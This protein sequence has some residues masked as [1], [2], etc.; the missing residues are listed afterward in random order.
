[1]TSCCATWNVTSVLLYQLLASNDNI[2]VAIFDDMS[3]D[4][5]VAQATA[6]GEAWGLRDS[7]F[8]S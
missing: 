6:L 4:D 7:I 8:D 3:T 1:M 5:A 2:H